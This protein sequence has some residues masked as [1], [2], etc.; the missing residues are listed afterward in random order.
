MRYTFQ[1]FLEFQ[2]ELNAKKDEKKV[3]E[4]IDFILKRLEEHISFYPTSHKEM[5]EWITIDSKP[6]YRLDEYT[7][8]EQDAISNYLNNMGFRTEWMSYGGADSAMHQ[9]IVRW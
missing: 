2:N 1:Q 9:L 5:F 7:A 3:E 4:T 8:V 6:L